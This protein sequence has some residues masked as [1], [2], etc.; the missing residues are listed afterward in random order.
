[1]G[2][3]EERAGGIAAATTLK[4]LARLSTSVPVVSVTGL[5]PAM[6]EGSIVSTAVALD[7][8][9]TVRVVTVIPVPKVAVVTPGINSVKVPDMFTV[10]A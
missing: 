9:F 5:S 7:G 2:L 4:P 10:S 1:L 3:I 8:E 6:A